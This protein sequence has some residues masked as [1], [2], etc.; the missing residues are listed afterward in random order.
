MKSRWVKFQTEACVI[1]NGKPPQGMVRDADHYPFG[2]ALG[3]REP[4][5]IFDFGV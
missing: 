1:G 3:D 2:G 5:E 4:L